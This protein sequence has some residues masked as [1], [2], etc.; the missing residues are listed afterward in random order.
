MFAPPK[1]GS[2]NRFQIFQISSLFKK[3]WFCPESWML[4][5]K[6][7][8]NRGWPANSKI[9]HGILNQSSF[10]PSISATQIGGD[11][12]VSE[13]FRAIKKKT[14]EKDGPEPAGRFSLGKNRD[15][16]CLNPDP[17]VWCWG[18][19][20]KSQAFCENTQRYTLE[21]S[22]FLENNSKFSPPSEYSV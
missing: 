20:K 6:F 4:W 12:M 17:F 13:R 2:C 10:D 14:M 5:A 19:V 15:P 3:K 8:L 22:D 21:R 16:N 7:R 18:N 1:N 9:S 11:K